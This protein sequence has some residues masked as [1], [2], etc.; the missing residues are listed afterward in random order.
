MTRTVI[1]SS[2]IY[3]T[4]TYMRESDFDFSENSTAHSKTAEP[5]VRVL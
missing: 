3:F 5:E 1:F 4:S 2:A